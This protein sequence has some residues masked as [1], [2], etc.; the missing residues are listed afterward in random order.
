MMPSDQVP[1][2]F[3]VSVKGVVVRAGRVILL[4]NA[5]GQWDLPGGRIELGETPAQC[6]AR[7]IA[8]ETRWLVTPGPILHAWMCHVWPGRQVFIVAY[9]CFFSAGDEPVL[10]DE[11]TE[12]GLFTEHEVP[13]L[14][15]PDGYKRSVALWFDRLGRLSPR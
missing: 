6:V 14:V 10:S 13:S 12:I 4:K 7:E 3:P 5:R 9:G 15:M 8:E 11:H 1:T 2:T